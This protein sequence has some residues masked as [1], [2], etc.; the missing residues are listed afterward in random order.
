MNITCNNYQCKELKLTVLWGSRLA[1]FRACS[2]ADSCGLQ[3]IGVFG[4]LE[5]GFGWAKC[6]MI[7]KSWVCLPLTFEIGTLVLVAFVEALNPTNSMS[8]SSSETELSWVGFKV[9][10]HIIPSK[11]SS[12]PS[13][14]SALTAWTLSAFVNI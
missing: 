4:K 2:M 14:L 5:L 7:S 8:S 11:Q 3:T 13:L 12:K 10:K 9:S 1:I 6:P